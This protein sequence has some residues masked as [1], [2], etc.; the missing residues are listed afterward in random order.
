MQVVNMGKSLKFRHVLKD[1]YS[2]LI[3]NQ[4]I[5]LKKYTFDVFNISLT[6]KS[7]TTEPPTHVLLKVE[8]GMLVNCQIWVKLLTYRA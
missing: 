6:V 5:L 1:F 2:W 4:L 3:V 7:A 8:N